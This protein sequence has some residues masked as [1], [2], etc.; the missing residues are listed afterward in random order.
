MQVPKDLLKKNI[1]ENPFKQHPQKYQFLWTLVTHVLTPRF[2]WNQNMM[3][4]VYKEKEERHFRIAYKDKEF[5]F[6]S[7]YQECIT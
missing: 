5:T 2:C 7:D 4:F 3:I 6:A 1:V